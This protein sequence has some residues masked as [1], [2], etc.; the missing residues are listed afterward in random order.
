MSNYLL[1][2]VDECEYNGTY[3]VHHGILG[4]RWGIRRYQNADGTLTAAGKKRYLNEDGSLNKKGEHF[5]KK[6]RIVSDEE[7]NLSTKDKAMH[8]GLN[9]N[10]YAII[11]HN[12]KELAVSSHNSGNNVESVK[13]INE[14]LKKFNS[15]TMSRLDKEAAASIREGAKTYLEQDLNH[16]DILDNLNPYHIRIDKDKSGKLYGEISY[17]HKEVGSD[18]NAPFGDHSLDFEWW[19][20]K[21]GKVRMSKS[22]S[23]NG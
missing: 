19:I 23:A 14:G 2:S 13:T 6:H 18:H 11:K 4:Q 9:N 16:K 7:A 22:F 5:N 8:D 1:H 20:D 3:L 10:G 21:N 17:E 12:G 15:N